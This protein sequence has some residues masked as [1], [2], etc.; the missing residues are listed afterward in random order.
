MRSLHGLIAVVVLGIALDAAAI[1]SRSFA[2]D[3]LH[4][5]LASEEVLEMLLADY[6]HD[7]FGEHFREP[8]T[9]LVR[10]W[11]RNSTARAMYPSC[12]SAASILLRFGSAAP[13][14]PDADWLADQKRKYRAALSKCRRAVNRS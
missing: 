2:R 7:A 10:R 1:D 13:R 5:T 9:Q 14:N 4:R 8:M 6:D 3:S 11:S 12:E